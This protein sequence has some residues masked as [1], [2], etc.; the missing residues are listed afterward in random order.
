MSKLSLPWSD[1]QAMLH[2]SARRFLE[3]AAP[4]R[5]LRRLR[6]SGDAIGYCPGTWARMVEQGWPGVATSSEH[7]GSGLGQAG[8][9]ILMECVGRTLCASPFEAT[10]MLGIAWL[11]QGATSAAHLAVL[12]AAVS[13]EKLL[14]LA[15]EEGTRYAPDTIT[16]SARRE[17]ERLKLSG[18]KV[19]VLDACVAD[20]FIVLAQV[21]AEGLT[22]LLVDAGTPGVVRRRLHSID[23]RHVGEVEFCDVIVPDSAI[24][25]ER[26]GAGTVLARIEDIVAAQLA[27]QLLGM[28]LRAFEMTC[29]YLKSREQFGVRIG[30]FQA[31]QHRA[32][33]LF[34]EL[35]TGRGIVR[36]ALAALDQGTDDASWLA[37]AAKAKLCRVSRLALNEAI[38]M[39]GGIGV[40]DDFDLGLYLKRASFLQ[41][42]MGDAHYHKDR[43]A[44]LRGY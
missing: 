5:Q 39:H 29:D 44:S 25:G 21:P 24:I 14:T 36:A 8:L 27:A 10:V 38:Q 33:H 12:E 22:A 32:A 13:G 1:E 19:N 42:F 11:E 37:S 7:G 3:D 35:E 17:G 16:A 31:L 28:S 23:S 4:V 20:H 9:G 6:E 34:T 2:D 43:F 15:L 18:R 30:S 41:H 26:G 40:T